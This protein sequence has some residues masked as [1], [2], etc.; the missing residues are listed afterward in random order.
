MGWPSVLF[1]YPLSFL[2]QGGVSLSVTTLHYYVLLGTF[3]D[4]D[5][6]SKSALYAS[7]RTYVP[8]GAA[9]T[10]FPTNVLISGGT[11]TTSTFGDF[12]GCTAS[13][14]T[15]PIE[16]ASNTDNLLL[17]VGLCFVQLIITSCLLLYVLLATVVM[18][19]GYHSIGKLVTAMLAGKVKPGAVV[20]V[21]DGELEEHSPRLGRWA[22]GVS[23]DKAV[24]P[25]DESN[26]PSNVLDMQFLELAGE[27]HLAKEEGKSWFSARGVW[28]AVPVTQIGLARGECGVVAPHLIARHQLRRMLIS[29]EPSASR[30]TTGDKYLAKHCR[31][32]QDE[33][34]P[35]Y[36]RD[37]AA[38]FAH[39]EGSVNPCHLRSGLF[40]EG[41]LMMCLTAAVF[42]GIFDGLILTEEGGFK[43]AALAIFTTLWTL[44]SFGAPV[45]LSW[46][47]GQFKNAMLSQAPLL[48][49][50]ILCSLTSY[51][52]LVGMPILLAVIYVVAAIYFIVLYAYYGTLYLRRLML[53]IQWL[54]VRGRDAAADDPPPLVS[55]CS[56][57][58][59]ADDNYRVFTLQDL[60][61]ASDPIGS[62]GEAEEMLPMKKEL[63]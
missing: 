5:M 30:M 21:G 53:W 51:L 6:V 52:F 34:I 42:A 10:F 3:S 14:V 20:Y 40:W 37:D 32:F 23:E 47:Q 29:N 26:P 15:A 50:G 45:M 18:F 35:Q 62:D 4:V 43:G 19:P 33:P 9:S 59:D 13:T 1:V 46:R 54:G 36:K 38:E 2:I 48:G 31:W 11:P 27:S 49:G 44:L 41:S 16:Y 63:N 8:E 7:L 57:M 12:W 60:I 58:G 56:S 39:G 22:S 24:A 55:P 28:C 61:A 17:D 25:I